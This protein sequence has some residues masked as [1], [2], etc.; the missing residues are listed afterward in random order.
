MLQAIKILGLR[1]VVF[2]PY[3]PQILADLSAD[4]LKVEPPEGDGFRYS[5]K[6]AKT[7]AGHIPT[8]AL[9]GSDG[10]EIAPAL[11]CTEAPL[12]SSLEYA[13]CWR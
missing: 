11:G 8:P 1:T 5:S 4:V 9:A 7:R 2:G 13:P 3:C 6:P 12:L 10:G